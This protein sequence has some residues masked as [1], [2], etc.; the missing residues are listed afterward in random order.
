[1]TM[2]ITN[3][4]IF[5]LNLKNISNIEIIINKQKID[6]KKNNISNLYIIY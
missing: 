5:L 4:I 2:K 1:M 3:F 6:L